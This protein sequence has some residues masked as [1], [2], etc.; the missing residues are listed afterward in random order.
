MKNVMKT[1]VIVATTIVIT[2]FATEIA[3]PESP[4]TFVAPPVADRALDPLLDVVLRLEEPE[5]AAAVRDVVHVVRE[6]ADELV[7]LV[8]ERRDER[9]ADRDEEGEREEVRG[10]QRARRSWARWRRRHAG[11]LLGAPAPRFLDIAAGGNA[12]IA[13]EALAAH[14]R[15]LCNRAKHPW[16]QR[17]CSGVP[18]GRRKPN[19]W[20]T[21]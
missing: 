15:A 10:L 18:S 19:R 8:D 13:S 1:I 14:R 2:P 9:E 11:F 4:S 17:R 3:T 16:R 5:P 21:R 20:S 6:L 12:P 7:H